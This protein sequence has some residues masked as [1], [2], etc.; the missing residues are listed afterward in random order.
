MATVIW[1]LSGVLAGGAAVVAVQRVMAGT[2]RRVTAVNGAS[3]ANLDTQ[4]GHLGEVER[5]VISKFAQRKP[6]ARNL[7]R[8][9]EAAETLGQRTADRVA[10]FGGSWSFIGVCAVVLGIW[11]FFNTRSGRP[12]DP[13]PFILLN[14]LL[15]C[16]AALQAPVILMSQNRQSEKDRL[17]AEADFAVNLKAEM[18]ILALHEKLDEL[19]E[20]RWR[21][22]VA[23]QERQIALLEQMVAQRA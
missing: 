21:A 10:R 12:F 2:L 7:P 17:H 18:E 23:Q 13:Y 20:T 4:F 3:P 14:L 6:V 9:L 16:M 11:I 15:S 8:E 19:R 22:L 1:L 5:G